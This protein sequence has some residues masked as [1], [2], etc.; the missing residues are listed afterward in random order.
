[1]AAFLSP[2]NRQQ[3]VVVQGRVSGLSKVISGVPQ[4][5]VLGPILFLL[6]ISDIARGVTEGNTTSSYV[7]DTRSGRTITD[8]GVDCEALQ[9]DLNTIYDWAKDVN[10]VFNS[11]KFECV[12]F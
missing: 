1:M 12:R 8:T 11:E 4:G 7:D 6:H 5:T 9:Q 2:E 3:A 10:M